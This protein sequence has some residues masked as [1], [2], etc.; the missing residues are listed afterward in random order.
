MIAMNKITVLLTCCSGSLAA[1]TGSSASPTSNSNTEWDRTTT[2]G[3]LQRQLGEK[4]DISAMYGDSW[5]DTSNVEWDEYQQA[6]RMLGFMVDCED[7]SHWDDDGYSGSVDNSYSSD[8]CRRYVLWAAYVDPYYEGGGIGEYQFLDRSTGKW[9]STPCNVAAADGDGNNRCAKMDCHEPDTHW[10]L[11]GLFKHRQPDDWMEQLFKHEGV[12]VWSNEEYAF[13]KNARKAWPKGCAATG[14]TTLSGRT[15]YSAIKPVNGGSIKLGLYTDEKCTEEYNGVNSDASK[16]MGGNFLTSVQ[17]SHDSG[18]SGN[19]DFSD[20]ST[21]QALEFWENSMGAFKICQPCIAYDINNYFDGNNK[22]STYGTYDCGNEN[23]YDDG[24][25]GGGGDCV[26]DNFDCYDDA[27]YT[28]VNQCMKFRAKTH[29]DPATIRDIML[30]HNQGTLVSSLPLSGM[31][32]PSMGF[33]RLMGKFLVSF[34]YL[35]FA[36]FFFFHAFT[37]FRKARKNEH[38][39]K[40]SLSM[41]GSTKEPFVFA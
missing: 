15:I 36:L 19:Y 34:L 37:Y 33:F 9:D 11:L 30:A 7:D 3:V 28:N 10:K 23:N 26:E 35:C 13:M 14:S 41:S 40:V 2:A 17:N 39:P 27:G 8:G 21:S 16:I 12:C 29:M 1:A 32:E 24:G 6:W 4:V 22:G 25:G 38:F 18:D 31:S 5:A 20:W